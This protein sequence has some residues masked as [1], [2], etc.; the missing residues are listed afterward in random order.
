MPVINSSSKSRTNAE[1]NALSTRLATLETAGVPAGEISDALSAYFAA[2]PVPPDM[3]SKVNLLE[4]QIADKASSAD[5]N[6]MWN[7]LETKQ[8]AQALVAMLSGKASKGDVQQ[9]VAGM[10]SMGDVQSEIAK[11][12]GSA[13]DDMNTLAELAEKFRSESSAVGALTSLISQKANAAD[14]Q[15]SMAAKADKADLPQ[16]STTT[17]PAVAAKSNRGLSTR[18]ALA[19]HT[20]EET[21]KY[22]VT[23]LET[24]TSG[25]WSSRLPAGRFNNSP[26]V[27]CAVKNPSGSFDYRYAVSGTAAEGFLVTV[28]WTRRKDNVIVTIPAIVIGA[29]AKDVIAATIETSTAIGKITFDL[30]AAEPSV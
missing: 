14:V 1:L 24:N 18:F 25:V 17:P 29:V 26:V 30:I 21:V 22:A 10:A 28:T 11:I 7:E 27:V 15:Q 8:D 3:S 16:P 19:D 13:P 5:V 6:Q 2:H 4:Q 23:G 20:H 9:A 12:V